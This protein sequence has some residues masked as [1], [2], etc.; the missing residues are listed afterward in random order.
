MGRC[1]LYQSVG[2]SRANSQVQIIHT[3]YQEALQTLVWLGPEGDWGA[4]AMDFL[5]GFPGPQGSFPFS[6]CEVLV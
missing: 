4:L 6:S 3:I 2:C 5:S 1:S